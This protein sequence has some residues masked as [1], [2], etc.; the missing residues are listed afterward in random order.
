MKSV[1]S[2]CGSLDVKSTCVRCACFTKLLKLRVMCAFVMKRVIHP[3][4]SKLTGQTK[5]MVES[6]Y[7]V[8]TTSNIKLIAITFKCCNVLLFL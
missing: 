5:W 7:L 2:V 8:G 4:L 3:S 1:R 6:K